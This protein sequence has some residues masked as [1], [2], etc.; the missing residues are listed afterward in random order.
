MSTV[1]AGLAAFPVTAA[2]LVM[3]NRAW[4]WL[5]PTGQ[6]R[7][8]GLVALADRIALGDV[9]AGGFAWC[10]AC[11]RTTYHALPSDGT[12]RCWTCRTTTGEGE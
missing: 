7:D 6:H 10:P 9:D 2:L 5:R 12:R 1:I 3:A 11:T 4:C 8:P